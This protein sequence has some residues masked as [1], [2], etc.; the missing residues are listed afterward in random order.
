MSTVARA[1]APIAGRRIR[2]PAARFALPLALFICAAAISGFDILRRIDP[3]DEGQM[4]LAVRRIVEG[5]WPYADF[6]FPY[7]P[8]HPLLLALA[9]HVLGESLLWWRLVRV[10]ADAT[11]ALLVFVIVRREA[12]LP[13]ALLAWLIAAT[14]MAEPGGPNPFPIALALGLGAFAVATAT[15]PRAGPG[16]WRRPVGAGALIALAA[17]W[18]L[19]FALFAGAAVLTAT[20]LAP[21]AREL[22]GRAAGAFTAAALGLSAALYAPFA[23]AA[24]PAALYD[25][26][27]GTGLSEGKYWTLPFPWQYPGPLRLF[28][29]W[30]LAHDLKK[31]IDYYVPATLLVGCALLGIVIIVRARRASWPWR[32]AGLFVFALGGL[33]YLRSRAD[34]FH[35]QPLIV[36]VGASLAIALAWMGDPRQRSQGRRPPPDAGRRLPRLAGV[37]LFAAVAV[38]LALLAIH[39]TTNRLSALLQSPHLERVGLPGTAG[40]SDTPANSRALRQVVP[41][42]QARVPP[43]QPIF[44]APRRSDLVRLDNLLFYVL[45]NRDSVLNAGATLEALPAQQRETIAALQRSRPR[46]V[47]RWIDPL[48][49]QSEPNLRGRSSGYRALDDYLNLFYR[50]IARFGVYVVLARRT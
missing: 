12:P 4:L 17:F 28:P 46:I 33:F 42:V 2:L 34:E 48:S 11:V 8:G 6:V 35:S 49:S 15:P 5:H 3:Y 30:S 13:M 18:R 9:Q 7:G 50:E 43:G 37:G 31:V 45:V 27:I 19:D 10:A 40:V 24:S 47:V 21:A 16:A 1:T 36:L 22:R 38:V 23:I 32:W 44:V 41:Y 26:M 20:A 29:P 14:G 25:Q 39:G